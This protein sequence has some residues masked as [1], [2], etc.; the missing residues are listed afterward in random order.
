MDSCKAQISV[1]YL[2]LT[3]FIL[4]VIIVPLVSILYTTASGSVQ[5]TMT[6]QQAV[7]LGNSLVNDA[8]QLYYLGLYSKKQVTYQVPRNVERMFIA[9]IIDASGTEIS[10]FG[11]K[12]LD[13]ENL[14]TFL[15]QSEVPLMSDETNPLVSYVAGAGEI[16]ECMA[17]VNTC[18]YYYFTDYVIKPGKKEFK[19]ETR[20]SGP[21]TKVSIIP[22]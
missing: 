13:P 20:L 14:Q 11:I 18:T 15:F 9:N 22:E 16:T 2:I 3:G 6:K 4:F 21:I 8:K 10:Y 5:E 12:F 17:P 7:E 1:E 19:L